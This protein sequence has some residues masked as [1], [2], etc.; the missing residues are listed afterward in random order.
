MATMNYAVELTAENFAEITDYLA[1]HSDLDV[2]KLF[3]TDY[4]T[5]TQ[6]V[7]LRYRRWNVY[8]SAKFNDTFYF[9]NGFSYLHFRGIAHL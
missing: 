7:P 6:N 2:S 8:N 5:L 9:N 3:I 1:T 4:V